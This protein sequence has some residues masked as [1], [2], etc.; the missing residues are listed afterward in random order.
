MG[1]TMTTPAKT[2]DVSASAAVAYEPV[3]VLA[4]FG[5]MVVLLSAILVVLST[6]FVYQ[7]DADAMWAGYHDGMVATVVVLLSFVLRTRVGHGP[8]LVGIGLGGALLVLFSLVFDYGR[9]EFVTELGG[10]VLIL[11]GALLSAS[12][13]RTA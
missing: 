5:W 8:A 1:G 2:S 12:G 7:N 9:I 6:W 11:L 13:R 4:P 10:G 3:P